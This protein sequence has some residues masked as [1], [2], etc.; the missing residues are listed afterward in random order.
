MTK[1]TL[2][3]DANRFLSVAQ[4]DLARSE[5]ANS[6]LLG[7]ALRLSNDPAYGSRPFFLAAVQDDV[8]LAAASVMTPPYSL[9]VYS[10]RPDPTAAFAAIA[11]ALC[12]QAWS[13]PGVNGPAPASAQF[14]TVWTQRTGQPFHLEMRLRAFELRRV[15]PPRGAPGALRWATLADLALVERWWDEFTTEA[16]PNEV[17]N[18]SPDAVRQAIEKGRIA[19]WQDAEQVV[20]M[21]ARSRVLLRGVTVS[22]VYTPPPLR[23]RGYASACVAALSQHLLDSGW[24][25]CTLFTDL[26]NP[27][28]NNIY[29][30]IGYRPVCDY[31]H[32][33]FGE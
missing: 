30:K 13:T 5:I 10:D 26:S 11:D 21:A 19:F 17:G 28:S 25:Y 16:M 22:L 12:G 15:T 24:Q 33:G 7:I 20:S 23:G 14:A 31:E 27:V 29:Q 18:R 8:G 9:V 2:Y 3:T 1:L 6:L 32:Y 4:A